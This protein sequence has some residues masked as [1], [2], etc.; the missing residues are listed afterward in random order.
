MADARL[1]GADLGR[2]R[3]PAGAGGRA[4]CG[5]GSDTCCVE[6]RCG[7]HVLI[8]DAGSGAAGLGARSHAKQGVKDFDLF[9]SHCHLDHIIGLPFMKPLYDHEASRRASMPATSRTGRP[10]R[11]WRKRFMSPPYFPVTPKHFRAADRLPATSAR[12]TCSRRIPGIVDPT[13]QAQPSRTAPS[14]TGS[15]YRRPL[16]LL[17]H[18]H[19][20]HPGPAATSVSS[21]SSTAPT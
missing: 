21:R 18:R 1:P 15:N 17:P 11:R 7:A 2:A 4:M 10:A 12:P 6:M 9:F 16:R 8:F 19:R 13:A 5:F 14:A 20:A 3:Q